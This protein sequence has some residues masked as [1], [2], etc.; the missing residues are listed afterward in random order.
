[1]VENLLFHEFL[2]VVLL[3]LGV[4]LYGVARRYQTA[5]DHA[6]GHPA[7]RATRRSQIPR[8]F[9]GLTTKPPCGACERGAGEP[10]P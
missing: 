10:R 7:K 3:W 4:I 1:M 2:L 5:V 6:H 8:P 9:P